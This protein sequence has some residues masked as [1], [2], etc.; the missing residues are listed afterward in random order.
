MC[1]QVTDDAFTVIQS[2]D[3]R[4]DKPYSHICVW[5][6]MFKKKLLEKEGKV[7]RQMVRLEDY[8]FMAELI[9]RLRCVVSAKRK[10][11]YYRDDSINSLRS[12]K[13][14]HKIVNSIYCWW[15]GLQEFVSKESLKTHKYW[16]AVNC[17]AM[18][19]AF[20]DLKIYSGIDYDKA[21]NL[22]ECIFWKLCSQRQMLDIECVG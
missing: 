20:C 15:K 17:V 4:F 21:K 3:Y 14:T 22:Q 13:D 7:F 11:Y 6:M 5:G 8:L 9:A 18:I 1:K 10:M 2:K 12:I 19:N 16:L